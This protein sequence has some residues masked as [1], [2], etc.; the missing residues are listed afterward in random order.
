MQWHGVRR[1][2]VRPSVCKL[3]RKS[4]LLA[5]KWPDR[6]QTCTRWTAGQ[7]ASRMCSRSRSKVTW[8][9]HFLGFLEWATPSLTVWLL[10]LAYVSTCDGLESATAY[11]WTFW[12]TWRRLVVIN[13]AVCWDDMRQPERMQNYSLIGHLLFESTLIIIIIIIM[14]C[15]SLRIVVINVGKKIKNVKKR[16]F[17]FPK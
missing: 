4:L 16:V 2:S 14:H 9:A 7:R 3:V 15:I 11:N 6:H 12:G 13:N 5:D 17:L 10:L 8:Y 1:L